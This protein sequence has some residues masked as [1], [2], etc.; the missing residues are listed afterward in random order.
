MVVYIISLFQP[1]MLGVTQSTYRTRLKSR[2][3][4]CYRLF[5]QFDF[6]KFKRFFCRLVLYDQRAAIFLLQIVY[7]KIERMAKT[8]EAGDLLTELHIVSRRELHIYQI[9]PFL[10]PQSY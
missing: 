1:S 4:V 8:L 5:P 2:S 10:W 7:I 3:P 9:F 6:I